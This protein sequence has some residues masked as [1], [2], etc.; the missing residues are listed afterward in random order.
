MNKKIEVIIIENDTQVVHRTI[1]EVY[2]DSN[3]FNVAIQAIV[4]N[5]TGTKPTSKVQAGYVPLDK[6][7]N[8]NNKFSD[9][10]PD[11]REPEELEFHPDLVRQG[12]APVGMVKPVIENGI[13]TVKLDMK[14]I[15][16]GAK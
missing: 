9:A 11:Y 16:K 2:T 1:S 10:V 3:T 14:S 7:N 6:I 4:E 8:V 5:L 12:A 13:P 15:L